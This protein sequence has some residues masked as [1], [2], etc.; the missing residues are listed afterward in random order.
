MD[1]HEPTWMMQLPC[2][3]RFKNIMSRDGLRFCSD[4]HAIDHKQEHIKDFDH[5][6]RGKRV[7][8]NLSPRLTLSH[9]VQSNC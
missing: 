1:V 2:Q 5:E 4:F 6:K 8:M 9:N 7:A 3:N